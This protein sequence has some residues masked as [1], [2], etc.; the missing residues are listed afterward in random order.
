VKHKK[1]ITAFCLVFFLSILSNSLLER[2]GNW[3]YTDFVIILVIV[4]I[5]YS[6]NIYWRTLVNDRYAGLLWSVAYLFV[7]VN[8]LIVS[9][10]KHFIGWRFTIHHF[11]CL[12]PIPFLVIYLLTKLP[13]SNT[14]NNKVE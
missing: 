11:Y 12:S 6:G 8:C 10:G 9:S 2:F 13:I 4:A 7:F 5:W 14:N 1:L 3:S